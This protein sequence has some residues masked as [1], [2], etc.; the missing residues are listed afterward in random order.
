M[1]GL[2][3]PSLGWGKAAVRRPSQWW[4][5]PW[6]TA[7]FAILRLHGGT[8]ALMAGTVALAILFYLAYEMFL[9]KKPRW[10][11]EKGRPRAGSE[12]SGEPRKD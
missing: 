6:T 4:L 11:Q 12:L 10:W 1:A 8:G 9:W 7:H 5:K 3:Q 2:H